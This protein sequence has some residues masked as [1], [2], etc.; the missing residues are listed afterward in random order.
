[1][2][3]RAVATVADL[4][5]MNKVEALVEAVIAK[6]LGV[7]VAMTT[8]LEATGIMGT[9][10]ATPLVAVIVTHM[11]AR[12]VDTET[13][14]DTNP[15]EAMAAL[16]LGLESKGVSKRRPSRLVQT[17]YGRR[18]FRCFTRLCNE[19]AIDRPLH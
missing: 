12:V 7:M 1:M 5:A 15:L 18:S 9:F 14:T 4:T 19:G 17:L 11:G 13:A 16:N 3:H 8:T 2:N 6:P 10:R